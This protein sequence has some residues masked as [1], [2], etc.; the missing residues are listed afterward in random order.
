MK[1]GYKESKKRLEAMIMW[2]NRL[3]SDE[4]DE[5]KQIIKLLEHEQ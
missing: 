5:L 2:S 3:G 4:V 1:G